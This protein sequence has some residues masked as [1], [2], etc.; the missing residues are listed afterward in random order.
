MIG[1][2]VTIGKDCQIGSQVSI[3]YAHIGDRV[4][5]KPGA[6]IGQSGFGFASSKAGHVKI[7]QRGRVIVQDDVEI[8]AGSTVDRG[9]LGDTVIGEGTKIDNLVQIAHNVQ[10]GRHCILVSQSGMAGSSVIEDFVVVGGQAAIA[11]HAHVGAVAR[12]PGG[13]GRASGTE[14]G[15]G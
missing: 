14:G 2:G 9:A 15:G 7:P 3:A 1:P 12:L 4:I 8:G 13:P 5:I 11:D 6:Q 10:I